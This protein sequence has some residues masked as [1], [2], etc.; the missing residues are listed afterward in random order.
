[1][2]FYYRRI[3]FN[4][5]IAAALVA[6]SL[7]FAVASANA[8]VCASPGVDG[9]ATLSGIVNSYHAGSGTAA[10][11]SNQVGVASIAGQ[12]TSARSLAVG[13]LVIVMQM[14]DSA[15]PANAGKYEYAQISSI[16]GAV[17]TLNRPLTNSYVQS[18]TAVTGA[19]TA[20]RTFQVVRVPQYASAVVAAGTAVSSDAWT[21]NNANGQ[22]TGGLVALD[23]AGTT[24]INGSITVNGAGFRGGAGFVS[25]AARAGGLFNDANYAF[26]TAA[27]NGSFKGEG[28]VGTPFQ[29]FN[30]TATALAYSTA[31]FGQGYPLGAAGQGAQGNAA[32]GGND[33]N[34]T[35]SNGQNSGG[36][37]GGN[38]GA[39][40]QGGNSWT[41]NNAAGGKGGGAVSNAASVLA[42]GGGG[43]GGSNNNGTD[44]GIVNAVTLVPPSPAGRTL[45]PTIGAANGAAGGISSS[46]AP[47]GGVVLLRTGNLTAG[48]GA[49]ITARG[50]DA[51]NVSG[52]SDGA[53]GGGAGGSISV[54]SAA[55]TGSG[56]ALNAAG[57]GGGY[58]DYF[59]HGPGGGGG[60][61]FVATSANLT[62]VTT[63]VAGGA[64]GYDGCCGG[65]AGN[66]SP[67][68]YSSVGGTGG[69]ASV[70]AGSPLGVATGSACLPQLT[71][72]KSTSTPTVTLPSGTTAQYSINV[73]NAITSG[74][75]YGV[76]LNDVLPA[77]FGL[78]AIAET[79][80]VS[81]AGTNT[82]GLT[83]T[84]A[85]LSGNTTTAV[86]GAGGTGNAPTVSSFTLFP[87][88][89]V[90]VTFTVNIN[91]A[92]LGATFQ[93]SASTTFTDPTR[94]TG[95]VATSSAVSNPAVS[96]GGAYASGAAVGGSN[97]LSSSS[98]TEDVTVV[99]STLLAATKTNAVTSVTAG[100][101]TSYTLT[102][103]NSGGYAAD[104]ALIKD[105]Q[106]AG[107]TCNTVTCTST[108][109]AAS[110]PTGLV[111][112]T[113]T[114]VASVPN[115]F[116]G[117]GI[118]IPAFPAAST[119]L[120]TVA[121]SV[122]ATGQ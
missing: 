79:G 31:T 3:A 95:G 23:V 63:N 57:G 65:T 21:V 111:L 83:P 30:G 100:G 109:G 42:L 74:A 48:A 36:G 90:T 62:A 37:G 106:S 35:A 87:G 91:S 38:S 122:T 27:F 72:T 8:Q 76:S 34:P 4:K 97:Y 39:G 69:L 75:A 68:P 49:A 43:G 14:Q 26:I 20:W 121:C 46:G 28:T 99:A 89:S 94:A 25:G 84:A 55:G 101:T 18:I 67:K 119:V 115:L 107:L 22:G 80:S 52:G 47:G 96:P 13:D 11:G 56:L 112:A 33:G 110:C 41:Q 64:L 108:T 40:G 16:T 85:N 117:T 60:G 88:G 113:P 1:M 10:A 82:S 93:N 77:P 54:I 114:A 53:G 102:F 92:A 120:L 104:N 29:V 118:T 73:S 5:S 7:V 86:F 58:S 59:D 44:G 45:P 9:P 24:A 6:F 17:L 15:V 50:Y 71:V 116:N 66:G 32:G 51:Y 70:S 81:F 105:T 61:G 2:V 19:T 103:S 12:R 98:T 78:Q